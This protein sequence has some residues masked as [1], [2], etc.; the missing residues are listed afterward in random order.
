VQ[1]GEKLGQWQLSQFIGAMENLQ[2]CLPF[3]LKPL[4]KT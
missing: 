1:K 3:L 2:L 4:R